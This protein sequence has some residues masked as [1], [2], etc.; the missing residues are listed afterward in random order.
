[1]RC[2]LR[3]LFAAVVIL[4][5]SVAGWAQPAALPAAAADKPADAADKPV[6]SKTHK[7]EFG[8]SIR[9]GGGPCVGLMGTFP[10]PID[11]PEQQVKV[12]N[13]QISPNVQR[14]SYRTADGLKQMLF[15]VPQLPTGS[16]AE[17]FITFE[18]T[19]RAQTPPRDTTTLVIPKDPPREVKK[20]LNPSPLIE[21]TNAKV[22]SLARELP[23]GKEAAWDQVQ[24]ILDGVREKVKFEQDPKNVFKGAIGALRDGKA[25]REDLTATFVAVCRAAK[26]PARMVWAMDYCYAEFYLEE[27]PDADAAADADEKGVKEKKS[28]KEGKTP[29]GAWYPCIVHEQK[30]LGACADFRPIMEKGDNFKVPEEKTVQRFVKEFL[31]GKGGTGGKPSVEFR[32]RN[33]D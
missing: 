27:R 23:V 7:W 10:V 2:R 22:R 9:A 20:F 13:E 16:T 30:E 33:A 14:H 25:D 5:P 6:E 32:R 1:M 24:A 12:V 4:A 19:K 17:C 21:T 3:W 15:E 26:I 18:I 29:K 8:T 11:W 28:A 31:T